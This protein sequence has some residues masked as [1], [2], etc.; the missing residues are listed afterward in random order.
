MGLIKITDL[1]T[2]L[3]LSSR[4]LRY[5]EE[6]GLITSIRP[7]HEKYRY[8]D[9]QNV[10]RLRQIMVLRKMQIPIKDI[11]RI[12]DS[13]EMA[14]ITQVFVDK[15]NEIDREVTAL[16]EL[17]RIINNFMH[18]MNEKGIKQITA[19]PLLY[20]ELDKQLTVRENIS[21]EQL[22]EVSE[23]LVRPLDISIV[24]LPKMRVLSSYLKADLRNS[25]TDAFSRY[26]QMSGIRTDHHGSFEYQENE[27]DVMISKI[28]D[29]FVNDSGFTDFIFDGGLFAAANLY[30][31][32][33]MNQSF[34]SLI[35]S[36][37]ENKFY[38]IDYTSDG[39]L[40]HAAM[41]EN[42]ISPD[43]RRQL[44]ALYV[45]VKK[46]IPDVTLYP[47]PT[48]V[49]NITAEEIN[50]QNPPLWEKEVAL[51]K[52]TPINDP[53]YRV[54]DS[55][56]AEYTGWVSERIL[57]TNVSVKL[58]FRVDIDFRVPMDDEQFSYGAS[59]GSVIFYHGSESY[60]SG[61]NLG[62]MDFGINMNNSSSCREEAIS[63]HQPIFHDLYNFP[64]RGRIKSNEYN[65]VT[66]IIG[67]KH[68][69]VIINDEIRYCGT[70]FPYMFLDL[71]REE[72]YPVVIGSNG[73][74]MK[75]FRK[76]KISQLAYSQTNKIKNGALTVN[77]KQSN[78]LIPIIH[79]VIT[80]E[81]G[82]YYRFNG[83]AG[84][85]M[86]CLGE[87]EFDYPFF[88]GLTGD[89][90]VQH[91]KQPFDGDGVTAHYQVNGD[92][93]FFEEVFEK[94]GYAA[95]YVFSR[96]LRKNKEMYLKTLIAYIDKGVPVISTGYSE[97]PYGV[98]VG[99]EEYGK[100][101]IYISGNNSGLQRI[102]CDKAMECDTDMSGWIFVGEKKEQKNIAEIYREAIYALPRL[103]TTDNDKYCFG[104]SAF[105]KWADDIESGYYEQIKPE[106]FDPLS[107][108]TNFVYVLATNGCCCHD[109]LRRA[110]ELNPDMTYLENISLLYKR[111]AD[112]WHDDGPNDLEALG[113]GFNI[114][115]EALQTPEK[116]KK[117]ASRIRECGDIIE[118]V[119][120]ILNENIK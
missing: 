99:Y 117:I 71:N 74:G 47:R 95:T 6:A 96:D 3:G 24:K 54:L 109:F 70:D 120:R 42:L 66:W 60:N 107:M 57:D 37:D 68:L 82:E 90:F 4:T 10:Q 115:L 21:M 8:Y 118:E 108:Y 79:R 106:E 45:P 69:A 48:E 32:D 50:D 9:E 97:Q 19:L 100:T 111:T 62:I 2:Q 16:S 58:P 52:I 25:D 75:Y 29:D 78:N 112:I 27:H 98:F 72:A 46:R 105:R 35:K 28:S 92:G 49:T 84:Y 110:N 103:L 15:L 76:I 91:Y 43:E 14:D 31:D 101:L 34:C 22:F 89:V 81:N 67:Q 1:G 104:V 119:V 61:V 113:G 87:K 23:T 73:Q 114:T 38:Q 11:V 93:K 53:H 56:E 12:Y 64:S 40:R 30:L 85:V 39:G 5:Y 80:N 26:I 77:T 88:A 41:T 63:F 55:G 36:F 116:R 17:K 7:Q 18:K 33:D 65:H 20:E 94:C 102:S 86:E 59:E 51:D 83:S 44:V 13:R